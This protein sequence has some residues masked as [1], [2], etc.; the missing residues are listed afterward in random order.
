MTTPPAAAQARSITNSLADI[1]RA[2][3]QLA[4]SVRAAITVGYPISLFVGFWVLRAYCLNSRIPVPEP[5]GSLLVYLALLAFACCFVML[6]LTGGPLYVFAMAVPELQSLKPA[7]VAALPSWQE[8][9]EFARRWFVTLLPFLVSSSSVCLIWV[10]EPWLVPSP[11]GDP[12]WF[13][14]NRFSVDSVIIGG[15]LFAVGLLAATFWYS[16]AQK[17]FLSSCDGKLGSLLKFAAR[18]GFSSFLACVWMLSATVSLLF[19]TVGNFFIEPDASLW[20]FLWIYIFLLIWLFLAT[21]VALWKRYREVVTF[22]LVVVVAVMLLCAPRLGALTLR[23]L[24][25]GG[26]LPISMVVRAV[27]TQTNLFAATQL[28]GCLVLWT[29]VHMTIVRPVKQETAFSMCHYNPRT[30]DYVNGQP[31]T[32]RVDTINLTD[33][34]DVFFVGKRSDQ[35]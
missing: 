26:G 19:L 23:A 4:G 25:Y 28:N 20:Y 16:K 18:S 7:N 29:S 22:S 33:V 15:I 9:W 35:K 3:E 10:F 31:V 12:I 13:W 27:D 32:A 2:L 24:G 21:L 5:D 14:G 11:D 30:L 1:T 17:W 8:A 34:L 6:L